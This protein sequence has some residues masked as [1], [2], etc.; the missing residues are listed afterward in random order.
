MN[1]DNYNTILVL[2]P[3]NPDGD[4][5]ASA[6]ALEEILSDAGKE[7]SIY[8]Y[9]NI[10]SY[11]HYIE[12]ADRITDSF[13][14]NFDLVIIVDT[15]SE[16]L[17]EKT[18][19]NH[20]SLIS[21]KPVYVLD[22]HGVNTTGLE[23]L[24]DA[25]YFKG[26]REGYAATGEIVYE[27][28]LNLSLDINSAA[29]TH[30]VESIL[31]DTMGLTSEAATAESVRI[32]Y[33]MI[34][35]GADL[36]KID[37]RRRANSKKRPEVVKFKGE[38]LQRIEY[39]FDGK[40]ALAEI[41]WPEIEAISPLYNPNMLF[42]EEARNIDGVKLA[43]SFKTYPDGKITAKIRSNAPDEISASDLAAIYGGG[44]HKY[45]AGFKVYDWQFDELKR[46]VVEN[47]AKLSSATALC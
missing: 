33:E 31:A 38:L 11:L 16:L 17:L 19:K 29:A 37:A 36:A 42:M 14:K 23:V 12:G 6:L 18:L 44:G 32:I 8:S 2:Q 35:K 40:L 30:I 39:L 28:A 26:K 27:L 41:S 43:I 21:K 15:G 4:S 9:S 3:E 13:P 25:I 1:F 7:V 47:F 24:P 34:L 22:H 46:D 45:A 10:P 5:V 20:L